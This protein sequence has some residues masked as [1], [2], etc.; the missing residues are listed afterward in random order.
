MRAQRLPL[1]AS[2]TSMRFRLRDGAV[3]VTPGLSAWKSAN[4]T[5]PLVATIAAAFAAVVS[6]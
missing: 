4:T 1:R 2:L 5:K 6:R 3:V